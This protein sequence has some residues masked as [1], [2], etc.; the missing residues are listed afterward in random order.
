MLQP[1]RLQCAEVWISIVFPCIHIH[2]VT[3]FTVGSRTTCAKFALRQTF[4]NV[5]TVQAGKCLY[6][7]DLKQHLQ[8]YGQDNWCHNNQ[9]CGR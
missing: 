3:V 2:K 7:H 1:I 8:V 6:F 4:R 5:A 9:R